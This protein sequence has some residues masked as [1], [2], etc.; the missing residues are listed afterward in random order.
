MKK[1]RKQEKLNS[2]FKLSMSN[3]IEGSKQPSTSEYVYG[4][5]NTLQ[6]AKKAMKERIARGHLERNRNFS[7]VT[8]PVGD[9]GFSIYPELTERT[10]TPEGKLWSIEYGMLE[11]TIIRDDSSN[12]EITIM[13]YPDC[14]S[15]KRTYF[16]IFNGTTIYKST[17]VATIMMDAPEYGLS[18][19]FGKE[20]WILS[21]EE[22]EWLYNFLQSKPEHFYGETVWQRIIRGY[23]N[24]I[25]GVPGPTL[26]EDLPMPDY[27][28]LA[29][30]CKK[31][32]NEYGNT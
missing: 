24:E 18:Q 2:I 22:V 10:Y 9:I 3:F 12:E 1:S 5:F 16:K 32:D 28:R 8:L 20:A 25:E 29:R 21:E 4:Y 15:N 14:S 7:I 19:A 13:V 17:K 30:Y 31:G 6:E 23:N 11:H 27:R 26:P